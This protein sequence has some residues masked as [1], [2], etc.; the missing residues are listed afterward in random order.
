M[1]TATSTSTATDPRSLPYAPGPRFATPFPFLRELRADSIG[2]LVS[3]WRE[4]GDVACIRMGT[5]RSYLV[6]RPEHVRQVLVSNHRGFEKGNLFAKLKK[7]AGDGL[8][9]S[10]G[11][12]W[13]AQR[14]WVAPAF[15]RTQ[16]QGVVPVMGQV[17]NELLA[18]WEREHAGGDEFDLLPEMSRLALDMVCRAMFGAA[19]PDVSF[20]R[21]IDAAIEHANYLLN[22]FV[23]P[24]LWV[25]TRRNRGLKRTMDGIH[26]TIREM[27]VSA[28]AR[29]GEGA[30][31]L[32]LLLEARDEQTGAAI[33]E[34]DLL[35]QMITLI[36]AGH[37][38]TAMALCWSFHLLGQAP[39]V[40]ARLRDEADA[41]L[42]DAAMSAE[43]VGRLALSLRV[44]KEA[45]RLFPPVWALPRQAIVDQEIGGY[46]VPRKAM[47]TL[48]P[49]ITHRHPEFWDDPE[50]FDPDR[51]LPERSEGRPRH[52]YFPFGAGGRSCVGEEFALLEA[53]L[54]LSMA[55]RRFDVQ[56]VAGRRVEPDPILTL[57][58]RNG[59]RVRLTAR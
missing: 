44:V 43:Q 58:P 57:R 54:V 31:L 9:F 47:V 6:A 16:V 55:V 3:L 37:E 7:V 28:R 50:T 2:Y 49:W 17:M 15:Q 27:V 48:S 51:F 20:H 33:E 1:A 19:T 42:S 8:L 40:T 14:H 13:R 22:N 41:V 38:T 12:T 21:H 45:M 23:T 10:E 59:L 26:G 30:D 4:Y 46:R 24:P 39:E 53:T 5:L 18:R 11:E 25:P 32:R 56:P 36:T 34:K 35:A 29:Q 52:A